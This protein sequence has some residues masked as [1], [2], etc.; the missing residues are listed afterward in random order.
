MNQNDLHIEHEAE[1]S[2]ATNFLNALDASTNFGLPIGFTGLR[3][4]ETFISQERYSENQLVL[5]SE[6]IARQSYKHTHLGRDAVTT[7]LIIKLITAIHK[8][9]SNTKPTEPNNSPPVGKTNKQVIYR[10][11]IRHFKDSYPENHSSW[12]YADTIAL[13]DL[14]RLI[15][16]D[17]NYT[18][19]KEIVG[20]YNHI[21]QHRGLGRARN[22]VMI[23]KEQIA[24]INNWLLSNSDFRSKYCDELTGKTAKS[25]AE[26]PIDWLLELMPPIKP[27]NSQ[28]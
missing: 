2:T 23:F 5:I 4:L 26:L 11:L 14:A 21:L 13:Y 6:M 15:I 28:K 16:L 24:D 27:N 22:D 19:T 18:L 8:S 12:S 20:Y 3:D 10:N 1:T 25:F 7:S 9:E 17:S